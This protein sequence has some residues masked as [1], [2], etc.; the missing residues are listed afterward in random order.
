MKI[1][2]PKAQLNFAV[3]TF[4]TFTLCF[5]PPSEAMLGRSILHDATPIFNRSMRLEPII[6]R[7]FSRYAKL[8]GEAHNKYIARAQ[9]LRKLDNEAW[10]KALEL[11]SEYNND[12]E[13]F[14]ER[15]FP[16]KK[17]INYPDTSSQSHS[18][19]YS[20]GGGSSQ[21]SGNTSSFMAGYLTRDVTNL[22]FGNNM[23]KTSTDTSHGSS[24]RTAPSS[25][26][27]SYSSE[28][29]SSDSWGSSG[30]GSDSSGDSGGGWDD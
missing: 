18:V 11:R 19:S 15:Y 22:M 13:A 29:S 8:N 7:S 3:L 4:S 1:N 12:W 20:G 10:S 17:V 16:K 5:P 6:S 28:N 23:P 14:Q 21:S 27:S 2:R 9:K 30:G 24:R 25:S 26:N